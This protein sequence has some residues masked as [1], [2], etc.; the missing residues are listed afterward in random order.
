M[1]AASRIKEYFFYRK[2]HRLPGHTTARQLNFPLKNAVF[3]ISDPSSN[4]VNAIINWAAQY[5]LSSDNIIFITP[6]K[7]EEAELKNLIDIPSKAKTWFQTIKEPW[8]GQLPADHYD[9]LVN[10]DAGFDRSLLYGAIRISAGF[11]VGFLANNAKVYDLLIEGTEGDTPKSLEQ[12]ST[13]FNTIT[14]TS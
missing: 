10:L 3:L 2:V 1:E 8:F 13:L 12:I 4:I 5:Q 14:T 7:P 9:L 11:K 6:K